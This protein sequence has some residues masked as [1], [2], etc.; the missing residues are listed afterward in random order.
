MT[1]S[2]L[3]HPDPIHFHSACHITSLCLHLHCNNCFYS[4]H[5]AYSCYSSLTNTCPAITFASIWRFYDNI[6]SLGHTHLYPISVT[7]P[8]S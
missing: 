8:N 2:L 7:F 4:L 3:V 1:L 6:F 5:T